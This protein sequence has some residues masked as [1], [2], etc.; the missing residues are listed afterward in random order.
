MLPVLPVLPMCTYFHWTRKSSTQS[1]TKKKRKDKEKN[2]KER[3]YK[4][5]P[6]KQPVSGSPSNHR[7]AMHRE[8]GEKREAEITDN[9]TC[10]FPVNL[11]SC[12]PSCWRRHY[13]RCFPFSNDFEACRSRLRALRNSN[14]SPVHWHFWR[15]KVSRW[16]NR[17]TRRARAVK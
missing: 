1:S 10:A 2:S 16:I 17:S 5:S 11:A 6:A 13:F 9:D 3:R 8:R 7:L 12:V 15:S 14:T 4:D